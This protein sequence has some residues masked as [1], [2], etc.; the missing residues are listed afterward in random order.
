MRSGFD[1]S[2]ARVSLF[3]GPRFEKNNARFAG[4]ALGRLRIDTGFL[5][6]NR[7]IAV[8]FRG[9]LNAINSLFLSN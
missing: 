1:R 3:N 7:L 5:G 9:R 2:G 4:N 8:R 6:A